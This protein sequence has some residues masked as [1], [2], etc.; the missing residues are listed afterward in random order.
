TGYGGGWFDNTAGTISARENSEVRFFTNASVVGGTLASEGAGL[1][2]V[3]SSDSV[4]WTDVTHSGQTRVNNN[5]WLRCAGTITNNG[6]IT[7]FSTGNGTRFQ[8][9]GPVTLTGGGRLILSNHN[10]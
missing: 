5:A 8:L 7:L 9:N 4:Y 10:N 3:T 1:F 2:S 6:D